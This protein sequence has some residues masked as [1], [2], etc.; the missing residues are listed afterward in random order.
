MSTLEAIATLAPRAGV[1]LDLDGTLAPIAPRPEEVIVEPGATEVIGRLRARFATVEIVTGRPAAEARSILGIDDIEVHG[2]YGAEHLP[3]PPSQVR[4][5]VERAAATEPGAWVEPK[6]STLA[7]HYRAVADPDAAAER[8]RARLEVVARDHG[9]ELVAGKRVWELAPPNRPG[10]G[11]VVRT[12]A[13]ERSL[14][15]LLYAGDDVADLDAFATLAAL[16]SE[17]MLVLAVAVRGPETP[18]ELVEAADLVVDGPAGLVG[19]LRRLA[20]AAGDV[21]VP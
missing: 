12:L 17:G 15:A 8:L 20:E 4:S 2:V 21:Q 3:P 18:V 19:V 11:G 6:G 13:R 5:A 7:L 16:G 1:A 10:K 9:L 14:A